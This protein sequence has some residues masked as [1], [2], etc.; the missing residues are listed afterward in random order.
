MTGLRL[1][2]RAEKSGGSYHTHQGKAVNA[3]L[4]FLRIPDSR[5]S[6]DFV[7]IVSAQDHS[8]GR[9]AMPGTF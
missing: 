7:F 3:P 2:F 1:T 8:A 9:S 5:Q 4:I 6:S